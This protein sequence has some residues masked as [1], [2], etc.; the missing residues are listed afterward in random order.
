MKIQELKI[1]KPAAVRNLKL[2]TKPSETPLRRKS[3]RKRT[4]SVFY[5]TPKTN[6]R[7]KKRRRRK[8]FDDTIEGKKLII[9]ERIIFIS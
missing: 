4:P 5:E 6:K 1:R 2:I 3:K 9:I 7:V 8:T